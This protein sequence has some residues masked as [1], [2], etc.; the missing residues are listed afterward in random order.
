[1]LVTTAIDLQGHQPSLHAF[2][3]RLKR[4]LSM[5]WQLP[6]K[7]DMN[8]KLKRHKSDQ[9]QHPPTGGNKATV[10][11]EAQPKESNNQFNH[12]PAGDIKAAMPRGQDQRKMFHRNLNQKLKF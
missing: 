12:P 2:Q 10:P 3:Q 8:W 1:M 6:S 5:L 7:K 11:V 9:I 4:L